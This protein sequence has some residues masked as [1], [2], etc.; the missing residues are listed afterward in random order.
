MLIIFQTALDLSAGRVG[1]V[2]CWSCFTES[3]GPG[4]EAAS[5][6]LRGKASLVL[7]LPQTT[8]LM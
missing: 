1:L 3:P 4:L 8:P 7:S 6:H 2:Q 5:P